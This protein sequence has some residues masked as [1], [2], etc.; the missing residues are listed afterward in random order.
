MPT[1]VA[2]VEDD[3]LVREML[4]GF[5]NDSPGFRCVCQF[6]NAADALREIPQA[7]PDV[8]LMDINMPGMSGIECLARLKELLPAIPVLMLTVYA[9]TDNIFHALQAGASCYLLKR[10]D[11]DKLLEA[12]REVMSGG[13]PMTGE[14]AQKVIATFRPHPAGRPV[15]ETPELSAREVEVLDLLARGFVAKEVADRL[16]LSFDTVRTYIRRIYVKL[17]ARSRGEAVSKYL[18]SKRP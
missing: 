13:V 11:P 18:K 3:R 6:E 15:P 12:I 5:L 1:K 10:T 8:V 17:H 9:D 7:R 2:I 16:Q 14:I 4:A